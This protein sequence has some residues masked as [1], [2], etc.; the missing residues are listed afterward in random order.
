MLD[1]SGYTLTF[2]EEFNSLSISQDASTIWSDIRR[3]SR[4]SL[5]A[6]I[7]FGDSAFVDPASGINPFSLQNGA[8]D[9]TAVPAG[10]DIVGPGQW[11]SGLITTQY[12]FAQQYGYFEVRAM[13]PSDVGV[14]PAF[15]MLPASGA[16][17]PELD[18]FEAYGGPWDIGTVHTSTDVYGGSPGR[19]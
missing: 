6:D 9:I 12:T 11:A 3:H 2:D 10:P 7:G 16:W 8:L 14:W 5:Y 17:P 13:L 18:V 1:L 15:W 19:R 4:M